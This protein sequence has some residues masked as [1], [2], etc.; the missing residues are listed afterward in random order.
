MGVWGDIISQP[1]PDLPDTP[2]VTV[3]LQRYE[4]VMTDFIARLGEFRFPIIN[5]LISVEFKLA[6]L[7]KLSST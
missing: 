5:P 1:Q 4:S 3:R 6:P 2:F 7:S